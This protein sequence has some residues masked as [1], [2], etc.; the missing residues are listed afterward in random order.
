MVRVYHD[1]KTKQLYARFH[2]WNY[3]AV[4][5]ASQNDDAF[6]F[7]PHLLVAQSCFSQVTAEL[8]EGPFD[9][10][11]LG[12]IIVILA[13]LS[14]FFARELVDGGICQMRKLVFELARVIT[15]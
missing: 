15:V 8:V 12:A 9:A 1:V 13:L 5:Y 6:N 14:V 2:I 10:A 4:V 7:Y 3:R 11:A